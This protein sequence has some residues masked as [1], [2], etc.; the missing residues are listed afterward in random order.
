MFKCKSLSWYDK[1]VVNKKNILTCITLMVLGL[2]LS[3]RKL[4]AVYEFRTLIRLDQYY[5]PNV[6]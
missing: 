5:L 4:Q 3:C 6:E 2:S 1:V